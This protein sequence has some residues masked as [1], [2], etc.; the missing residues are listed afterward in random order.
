MT[1][2]FSKDASAYMLES[3]SSN[4]GEHY[5]LVPGYLHCILVLA[6][7]VVQMY[8]QCPSLPGSYTFWPYYIIS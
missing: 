3:W 2:E 4:R 7:G 8:S 1:L 6:L 5:A